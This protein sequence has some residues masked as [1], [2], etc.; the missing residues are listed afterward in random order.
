MATGPG[1]Q[2]FMIN[3]Q[4]GG[5]HKNDKSHRMEIIFAASL[6]VNERLEVRENVVMMWDVENMDESSISVG[7]YQR[8]FLKKLL[9]KEF[10]RFRLR[11]DI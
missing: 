1:M 9:Q 3:V 5:V 7:G 11:L 2:A 4:R 10:T 6:S 8:L